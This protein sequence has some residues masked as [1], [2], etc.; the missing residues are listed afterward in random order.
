LRAALR[1]SRRAI[2]LGI[3]GG[4]DVVGALATARLCEQL[5]LTTVLGGIAWERLPIDPHPGP[6]SADEIVGGRP[7]TKHVVLAGPDTRTPEGARFAEARMAE[8]LGRDT[9]LIDVLA[10]PEDLAVSLHEAAHLLD[11]DLVISIDVGGDVLANGSERGLAS[12]LCDAV[13][14]AATARLQGLGVKALGGV[15]GAGC[16]GELSL[17]EVL[18]RLFALAA[19]GG[20][21]GV[22]GMPPEVVDELE[23]V[24]RR[25]PTEA[26]AQAVRC[27]RGEVGVTTIRGGRRQVTLSPLG[28]LTFYFDPI[29]AVEHVATL[30]SAVWDASTLEEANEILHKRGVRTEFDFERA[31]TEARCWKAEG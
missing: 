26:S 18:D 7:L 27:A 15:F 20:L 12:P 9:L 28:A 29:R 22:W 11:A 31:A 5:G 24:V 23:E 6:R 14:L 30:A 8:Y 2:V 3:G 21:Q 10:G 25:I 19:A 13:M 16:D 1:A 4:G 17:E